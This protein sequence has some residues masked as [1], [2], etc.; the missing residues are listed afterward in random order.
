VEAWLDAA[1]AGLET[2]TPSTIPMA[3]SL[4]DAVRGRDGEVREVRSLAAMIA[5]HRASVA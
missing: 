2:T 5:V 1:E 4:A 3:G